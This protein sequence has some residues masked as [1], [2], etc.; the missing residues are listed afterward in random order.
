[1]SGT[2]EVTRDKAI[3][4]AM[5]RASIRS[6]GQQAGMA[7]AAMILNTAFCVVL[8][9]RGVDGTALAALLIAITALLL[10]R[11]IVATRASRALPAASHLE[12]QGFDKQFRILSFA[13]QTVTGALIW[14]VW[15]THDEISAY[16]VTLLICLYAIGTMINLS[17]D[18][19][20]FRSTIP[21]LMVQPT[22]FW[23]LAGVDGIAIA[24]ILMGL[25]VLMISSVRNSQHTFEDSVRIRFEK[26]DLLLQ[27]EREKETALSALQQAEAANRS[28]SFFMAAASH[29]LRQPLYAATILCDTL[30][31]HKLPPE[32]TQLLT[33]QGK[34]LKAASGLFDTLLDLTKFESGAVVPTFAPVN[35]RELLKEIEAEFSALCRA[36]DLTLTVV[37]TDYLAWSDYDLLDRMMRNLVSNAVRYTASGGIRVECTRVDD[38]LVLAVED[39]GI[40]IAPEDQARIFNEFVQ[41][42]NPQRSRDRGAGLGL[43]I[44]RHI[45]RL[46]G[47]EVT[48]Q[49][50]RGRGT[51]MAVRVPMVAGA[52]GIVRQDAASD[53]ELCDLRGRL[54][55]IVDDDASVRDALCAYF[56]AR[57][58]RCDTARSREELLAIE[59]AAGRLPDYVLIDDMLSERESGLDVARWLATRTDS[60]RILL[61][62][63]NANPDRMRTL[64]ESSFTVLQK[65]IPASALN[66]WLSE[67]SGWPQ[68][69][70]KPA[71][72]G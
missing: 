3:A 42:D 37:P 60:R 41:I 63:G 33:Q 17:A 72:S 53:A 7:F 30:G 8:L 49:S 12:L 1:M 29:D 22:L 24:V 61:M 55:W 5:L 14:I 56:T 27:V 9:G 28:K 26:D 38:G 57:Q 70:A 6:R 65:P 51:R 34:A 67:R 47:C 35:V 71:A 44:V 2:G 59:K 68:R 19:R 64:R 46:L 10:V 18:Y 23:L 16:V 54:V 43:A 66:E 25:T 4:T 20:S 39:T 32:A 31:L 58:C 45:S 52:L 62:T 50:S 40:G 69:E 15:G 13:S 11:Y 36:K 21:L 48:V